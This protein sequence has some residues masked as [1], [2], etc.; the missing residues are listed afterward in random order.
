MKTL[1]ST[2]TALSIATLFSFN[3]FAAEPEVEQ[4]VNYGDPTASFSTVGISANKDTTQLNG[5]V[6]F[7]ANI[8]QLD[9]A[10]D[11]KTGDLNGR[12]RY[13]HVT[14]GLGYSV[15][16]LADANSQTVLGG[17]IYKFQVTDNISIFPM[18]SGGAT[19]VKRPGEDNKYDRSG[20]AQAGI[21]AMYGFDAGHWIYANPK[22]TYH[23]KNKEFINQIEVGGGFMVTSNISVGAK[24]EY[25]AEHKNQF[26]TMK[27]DTVTWLQA[28]YYF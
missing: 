1:T 21:Y 24:V 10:A 16:V 2:L 3:A 11:N 7:G 13:F 6:G 19:Q 4:D 22:T 17:L 27:A 18:L 9:I 15:D 25:T 26:G 23:L 20:L 14:D 8:F 28:N 12:G 5:M